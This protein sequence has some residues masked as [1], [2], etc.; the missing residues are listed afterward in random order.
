VRNFQKKATM[1]FK[2]PA[3]YRYPRTIFALKPCFSPSNRGFASQDMRLE[4]KSVAQ[5]F[6]PMPSPF[7]VASAMRRLPDHQD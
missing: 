3:I 5:N 4:G 6:S 1:I 2:K 7:A